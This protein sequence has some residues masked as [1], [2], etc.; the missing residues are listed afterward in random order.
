VR[1]WEEDVPEQLEAGECRLNLGKGQTAVER[2]PPP[3]IRPCAARGGAAI[4]LCRGRVELRAGE[5]MEK[6]KADLDPVVSA[7]DAVHGDDLE[8]GFESDFEVIG[9]RDHEF[10]RLDHRG[11]EVHQ[12]TT[13]RSV[14]GVPKADRGAFSR[15]GQTVR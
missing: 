1:E 12:K 7:P 8:S 9:V 4:H 10:E 5:E 13:Q 14:V 11:I 6:R 2:E 15:Q 3:D